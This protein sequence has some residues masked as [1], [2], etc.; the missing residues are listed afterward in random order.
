M[1][2]CDSRTRR[3]FTVAL[4]LVLVAGVPAIE[5]ASITAQWNFDDPANGGSSVSNVGGFAGTM[6]GVAGRTASGGGVSATA[7]DYSLDLRALGDS[8]NGAMTSHTPAFLGALNAATGTQAFSISYWQQLDSTPSSTSF[9]GT[10][11]SA[12][13]IGANRGLNAHS[14]WSDGNVYFDTAG[15]CDP[16]NRIFGVMGA[17]IG[18]WQHVS[19][20]F[21]NGIREVYLNST[22]VA[23]GGGGLSLAADFNAFY[24]GNDLG[25]TN[26]GMDGRLD[27]FTIWN[28]ALTPQE[29]ADLSVRPVPEPATGIL[30][31]LGAM[32]AAFFRS[33]RS[34][35]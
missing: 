29:V 7:G 10:S 28:G 8:A 5:A 17:V 9:W 26:L 2:K 31:T 11:P 33:R 22:L 4:V 14:P 15:C 24:I 21:N 23:S 35:Q 32:A 3:A 13:G 30:F 19:F 18:E 6:T 20:I 27:N 1:N 25:I 34:P 16:P 12:V